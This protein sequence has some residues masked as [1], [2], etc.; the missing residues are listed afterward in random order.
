MLQLLMEVPAFAA[1]KTSRLLELFAY[2]LLVLLFVIWQGKIFQFEG[3]IM[4][5]FK[6]LWFFAYCCTGGSEPLESK[7]IVDGVIRDNL[8]PIEFEF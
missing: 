8:D 3:S 4:Y 2:L 1:K 5:E 7:Y 6:A